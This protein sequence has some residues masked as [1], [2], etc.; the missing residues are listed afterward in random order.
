MN[1]AGLMG[2]EAY[3]ELRAEQDLGSRLNWTNFSN[4]THS[5]NWLRKRRMYYDSYA[6]KN[7][8]LI[9]RKGAQIT[10]FLFQ[11]N[12]IEFILYLKQQSSLSFLFNEQRTTARHQSTITNNNNW[13]LQWFFISLFR[14]LSQSKLDWNDLFDER[15]I[16]VALKIGL[17]N[18]H[19]AYWCWRKWY[20]GTLVWWVE[21]APE[22]DDGDEMR[23]DSLCSHPQ[24][25]LSA[26]SNTKYTSIGY[27][28]CCLAMMEWAEAT[29]MGY[30]HSHWNWT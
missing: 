27:F 13:K 14:Q 22:Y 19:H 10:S 4:E 5:I 18:W 9:F 3:F 1:D 25:W 8:R 15:R 16:W 6:L 26:F 11:S 17:H 12:R 29:P 23:A 24:A 20:H 30:F 21:C 28:S 2:W 7:H